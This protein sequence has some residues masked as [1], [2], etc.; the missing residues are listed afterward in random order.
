MD[1]SPRWLFSQGR[2][3]EAGAIVAKQL[4]ANG[5]D[6]LV[7]TQGRS[8]TREEL[9]AALSTTSDSSEA[10]QQAEDEKDEKKAVTNYGIA[11]LFKTPRL[12]NRTFNISLNW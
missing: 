9:A 5:K 10:K 12:R 1:E 4:A 7:P 3:A 6:G 11:H 8:F 2:F